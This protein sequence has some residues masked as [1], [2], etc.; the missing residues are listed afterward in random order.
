M[1]DKVNYSI[2]NTEQGNISVR[3]TVKSFNLDHVTEKD[4]VSFYNHFSTFSAWDTGLLPV[5]GS[6]ILSIRTAGIYTQFAYQHK[7][8]F[9][10]LSQVQLNHSTMSTFLIPIV[11]VTATMVLVGSVYIRMKIGP[12][13]L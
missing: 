11:R 13:F 12:I 10:T 1:S 2:V 5:E 3:S 7:P 4:I 8:G 6:G 9:L